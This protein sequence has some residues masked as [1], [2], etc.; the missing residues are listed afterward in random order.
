VPPVP[1]VPAHPPPPPL[2]PPLPERLEHGLK[3]DPPQLVVTCVPPPPPPPP[4]EARGGIAI[5]LG[6]RASVRLVWSPSKCGRD[7]A[8]ATQP[9]S[10]T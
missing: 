10:R 8:A 4:P 7:G 1:E 9:R 5:E 6:V 3:I 2:P